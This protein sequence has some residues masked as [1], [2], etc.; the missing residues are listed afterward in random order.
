MVKSLLY[1]VILSTLLMGCDTAVKVK[2]VYMVPEIPESVLECPPIPKANLNNTDKQDAA[3]RYVA[4]LHE[5]AVACK[6]DLATTKSIYT[7]AKK[8]LTAQ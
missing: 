6:T 7:E 4:R 5:V 1:S 8:K 3:A 2:T